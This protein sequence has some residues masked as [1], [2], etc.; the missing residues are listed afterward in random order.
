MTGCLSKNLELCTL[1][2]DRMGG[3]DETGM[4]I[5]SEQDQDS[6]N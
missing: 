6:R 1:A 4:T 5:G 3:N 2:T